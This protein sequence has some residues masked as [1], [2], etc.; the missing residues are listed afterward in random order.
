M[1]SLA[2][3]LGRQT[4]QVGCLRLTVLPNQKVEF[5]HIREVSISREFLIECLFQPVKR[6]TSHQ[7]SVHV[8]EVYVN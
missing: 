6:L 1:T 7:L 5:L 3:Q 4:S 8:V 2:S